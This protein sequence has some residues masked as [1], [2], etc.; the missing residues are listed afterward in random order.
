MG[1]LY[2]LPPL[3]A[4]RVMLEVTELFC[5]GIW[6]RGRVVGAVLFVVEGTSTIPHPVMV[7][8][9]RS[10]R[11]SGDGCGD[12][13]GSDTNT[14]AELVALAQAERHWRRRCVR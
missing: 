11:L 1:D 5:S 10:H 7:S 6:A 8:P 12:R 2:H 14:M 13:H 3:T 4:Q 9:S